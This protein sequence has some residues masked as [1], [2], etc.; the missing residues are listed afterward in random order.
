M[1]EFSMKFMTFL[2]LLLMAGQPALAA[3]PTITSLLEA[4]A[5]QPDLAVSSLEVKSAEVQLQQAYAEL[6]PKLSAFGTYNIY[7]SPTN[8]RPMAPTE[9]NLAAGESIPFSDTILRYG[10]KVEMPLFVKNLYSLAD[11]VEQL[12][13]VSRIGHKLR[14][15]SR[16][17]AVVSLDASLAY[18]SH[19]DAAIAARLDS[20]DKTR[21]DLSLAVEN[22]RVPEAE[23]LKLETTRNDLHKQRNDLQRQAISLT[24]QVQQLTGVRLS[25][26]VPLTLQR[27]VRED[28]YLRQL[29]Q[30]ARVAA[31]EKEL[32]QAKDQ[33]YP[34][35]RLEGV[36]SENAGEAYNTGAS[37]E[38]S[39]NYVGLA[40]SIPLFDRK[41]R[42]TIDQ[43]QV[44]LQRQRQ[45]LAQLDLDLAA[46]AEDLKQ[47]LPVIAQS[48][49]LAQASLENSQ[50]L[51]DIAKVARRTG[52]L[53][54]E[55]YLRFE[56][57]VLEAEAA[58]HKTILD[59]WQ[60][61][62]QQA[63]LYGEELTGVVQ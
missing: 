14:L 30:Q 18:T 54:T 62:S 20:L 41:L 33:H 42:T 32:R 60:I 61:I 53:S 63:V 1:K 3:E 8:L 17:A 24:G 9:V 51:L 5:R 45:Q 15:I 58:L 4:V 13:Q 7:S 44:Q 28:Q 21:A 39:Y 55:E 25:S 31:S 23:L 52:R 36:I 16:Q 59:R 6:Y 50:R 19:L 11:K 34:S 40:L 35:L 47:Q 48:T 46:E 22:G 10:L 49:R 26:F 38:R 57:G 37:I 2:F 12:Q 56:T 27:P 29:Q 43:A